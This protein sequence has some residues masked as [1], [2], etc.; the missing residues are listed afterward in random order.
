MKL[1]TPLI[2]AMLSLTL[3]GTTAQ[4]QRSGAFKVVETGQTF[5]RA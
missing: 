1:K 2:A 4:A 5:G 3:A